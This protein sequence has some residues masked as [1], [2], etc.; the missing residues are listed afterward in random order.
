M[1]CESEQSPIEYVYIVD[2][3]HSVCAKYLV[4]DKKKLIFQFI[5]DLPL[6]ECDGNVSIAKGEW[7]P[8]RDWMRKEIAKPTCKAS[9][10][11]K[12]P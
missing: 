5:E 2:I 6:I 4:S 1:A 11:I 8:M 3:P 7:P 12:Q 10:P 9:E